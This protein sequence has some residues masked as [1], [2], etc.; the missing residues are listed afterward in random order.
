MYPCSVHDFV[1]TWTRACSAVLV[2]IAWTIVSSCLKSQKAKEKRSKTIG[3]TVP[4]TAWQPL[5]TIDRLYNHTHTKK[6]LYVRWGEARRANLTRQGRRGNWTGRRS[7]AAAGKHGQLG[8]RTARRATATLPQPSPIS[9]VTLHSQ[10][11][12]DPGNR[13]LTVPVVWTYSRTTAPAGSFFDLSGLAGIGRRASLSA[14]LPRRLAVR[15][16]VRFFPPLI[17]GVFHQISARSCAACLL[18]APSF[19][20]SSPK[21]SRCC[22]QFLWCCGTREVW[23]FA[24]RVAAV[25]HGP[26][27]ATRVI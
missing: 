11:V 15:L 13:C 14:F 23:Q 10:L 17:A 6:K 24:S 4:E 12:L 21:A 27:T 16:L 19:S 2:S 8:P 26:C 18:A 20:L 22:L 1:H 7:P 25:D 3:C 9:Q 5:L